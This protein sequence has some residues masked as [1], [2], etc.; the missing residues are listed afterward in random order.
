M[1]PAPDATAPSAPTRPVL[2]STTPGP[3][4][5]HRVPHRTP[6]P[7][8]QVVTDA[9]SGG[10]LNP[11]LADPTADAVVSAPTPWRR[12]DGTTRPA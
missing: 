3:H 12:G 8:R 9:A 11:D 6:D 1:S 7:A 4:R 10:D 2:P 5:L